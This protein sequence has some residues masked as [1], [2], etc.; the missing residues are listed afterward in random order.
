MQTHACALA[1]SKRDESAPIATLRCL[2]LSRQAL[3]SHLSW[4]SRRAGHIRFHIGLLLRLCRWP[5]FGH[6][7]TVQQASS[8]HVAL[9]AVSLQNR[10]PDHRDIAISLLLFSLSFFAPAGPMIWLMRRCAEVKI[11]ALTR[12]KKCKKSVQHCQVGACTRRSK[13]FCAR[14][15]GALVRASARCLTRGHGT[16]AKLRAMLTLVHGG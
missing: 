13:L 10:A 5:P 8:M 2:A 16:G 1:N 9:V 12:K 15:G 6:S 14:G 11:L 7:T 4:T 3:C